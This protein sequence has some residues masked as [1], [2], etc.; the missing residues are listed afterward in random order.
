[1]Q[2]Q[3]YY[4]PMTCALVPFVGLLEAG[5]DFKLETLNTRT[6]EHRTPEFL[7]LNPKHKVP[8]LAIDGKPLTENVAIQI[9]LAREFPHA[10]LL[11]EDRDEYIRA[12]SLMAWCASTIHP[13]LT[14]NARPQLYCDLPGTEE[15]VKRAGNKLLFEDLRIANDILAGREWLLS[16][17]TLVDAY[18][19]W[20]LRRALSF[21]LDLSGFPNCTAHFDRV[22]QRASV[23]QVLEHDDRV[24]AQR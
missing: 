5:A 10:R 21:G 15:A 3:L 7:R 8:V 9:W 2:L 24:L 1:M 6:N 14:P 16:H 13:H 17:F 19:F 11:P 4:A 20:A 23:R 18:L 12:V 22:G